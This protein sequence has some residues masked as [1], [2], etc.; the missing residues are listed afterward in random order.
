MFSDFNVSIY[1][2]VV[3]VP[4][5]KVLPIPEIDADLSASSSLIEPIT[6]Y[7]VE[8]S[9]LTFDIIISSIDSS[10]ILLIW[11][12]PLVNPVIDGVLVISLTVNVGVLVLLES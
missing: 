1:P 3:I 8:V 7:V 9:V 4:I 11:T 10:V 2:G 5:S 12:F 6:L